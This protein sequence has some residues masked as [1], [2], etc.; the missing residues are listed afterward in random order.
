[1]TGRATGTRHGAAV[2]PDHRLPDGRRSLAGAVLLHPDGRVLLQLRDDKPGIEAPGMWSLFGGG[3]DEGETPVAGMLRE[4][5]EEIGFGVRHYRPLVVYDGWG[6]RFHVYLAAVDEPLERLTLT[7][8]AGFDYW[9]V[10]AA[11]AEPRLTAVGRL[12]L[13]A[14][15]ALREERAR[16]GGAGELVPGAGY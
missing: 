2:D 8:G 1:M 7:E 14:L 5:R 3:L 9:D 4:V 11:L 6:G 16:A 10:P 12:S 13:L 15:E